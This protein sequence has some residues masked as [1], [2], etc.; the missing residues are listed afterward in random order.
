MSD[1]QLGF[2][3]PLLELTNDWIMDICDSLEKIVT[4]ELTINN[5]ESIFN[6]LEIEEWDELFSI[7]I[8]NSKDVSKEVILSVLL[9]KDIIL[10]YN[11]DTDQFRQLTIQSE[12][13]LKA[14]DYPVN[15]LYIKYEDNL[16]GINIDEINGNINDGL[17]SLCPQMNLD[18]KLKILFALNNDFSSID[19]RNNYY[20]ISDSKILNKDIINVL[21]TNRIIKR[22]EVI[23]QRVLSTRNYSDRNLVIDYSLDDHYSQFMDTLNG[24]SEFNSEE[25]IITK[26][27]YLYQIFE[28]FE[29]RI[30]IGE[31]L[32]NHASLILT[33]ALLQGISTRIRDEL[34]QLQN[35]MTKIS[36][37]KYLDQN[38]NF[39]T[40]ESLITNEWT[41]S[42]RG[43][44]NFQDLDNIFLEI[45]S[46]KNKIEF[47]NSSP[48]SYTYKEISE[49]L[50]NSIYAI[51]CAIVHAKTATFHLNDNELGS[52][53]RHELKTYIEDVLMPI[54]YSV[55]VK[56]I[57][58]PGEI[59]N[60]ANNLLYYKSRIINLY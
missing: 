53:N 23:H 52:P 2:L 45:S 47:T 36:K 25:R 33:P 7:I 35:F 19:T 28:S 55:I 60:Q 57:S 49:K 48:T 5:L 41:N 26:F 34:K 20:L 15:G 50:A 39:N 4:K 10:E 43:I 54:M 42:I 18:E 51:R 31:H 37:I 40:I 12:W 16:L 13:Y 6:S 17:L 46:G 58:S 44:S 9:F 11:T 56:L 24:L 38:H 3:V 21:N 32:K 8:N 30:I 14:I 1:Y 27:L 22:K 29:I 59:N